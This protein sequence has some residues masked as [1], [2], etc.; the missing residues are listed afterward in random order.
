MSDLV[1]AC[2]IL[3]D[4]LLGSDVRELLKEYRRRQTSL[5]TSFGLLTSSEKSKV[6]TEGSQRAHDVIMT[7]YQRRCDVMTSHRRRYDVIMTSCACW[8]MFGDF[9]N[10]SVRAL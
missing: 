7:S 10:A 2:D 8:G 5:L 1:E 4:N 3:W 9:V 6:R